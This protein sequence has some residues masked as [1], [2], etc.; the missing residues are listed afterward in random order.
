MPKSQQFFPRDRQFWLFHGSAMA[1]GF[2]VSVLMIYL[3]GHRV[4]PKLVASTLWMP[5]YTV[6]V[7]CFR[8]HYRQRGW[9]HLAMGRLIPIAVAYSALAGVV[10]ALLIVAVVVPPFIGEVSAQYQALR[11][12]FDP[13]RFLGRTL[14][15]R[16]IVPEGENG[17]RILASLEDGPGEPVPYAQLAQVVYR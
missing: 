17:E 15:L 6:A 1:F 3:D 11:L 7:L 5:L 14:A 2:A 16:D 10:I 8:W 12:P 4:A 13:Q 9:K